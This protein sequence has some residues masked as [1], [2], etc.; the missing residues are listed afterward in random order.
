MLIADT[1]CLLIADTRPKL[2]PA[3]SGVG[4]QIMACHDK[5]GGQPSMGPIM[6]TRPKG[7]ARIA[8]PARRTPTTIPTPQIASVMPTPEADSPNR[9]TAYGTYTACGTSRRGLDELDGGP[10]RRCREATGLG[11]PGAP[12]RDVRVRRGLSSVEPRGGILP[13]TMA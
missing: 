4:T 12:G 1:R 10:Q 13:K 6:I 9:C 2:N 7:S 8:R 5:R 3:R 11:A